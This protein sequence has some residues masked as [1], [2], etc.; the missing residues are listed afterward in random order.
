MHTF[1]IN[2]LFQ[3]HCLRNVS[4]N[5]VFVLRKTAIDHTAYMD[6]WKNTINLHVKFFLMM[7]NWLFET[8]RRHYN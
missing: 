4:N 3:L 8:R 7:D 5:Q 1:F 2:Y 6:S